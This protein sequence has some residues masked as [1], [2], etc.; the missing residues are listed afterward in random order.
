MLVEGTKIAK[1]IAREKAFE[2]WFEVSSRPAEKLGE[3][4]ARQRANDLPPSRHVRVG[5]GRGPGSEGQ[6]YSGLRVADASVMPHLNRG[7]THAPTTMVAERAAE[8]IR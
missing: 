3:L 5:R 1:R 6:G 8:L 2:P 4:G 7:H